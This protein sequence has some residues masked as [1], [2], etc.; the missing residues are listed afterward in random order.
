MAWA[1]FEKNTRMSKSFPTRAACWAAAKSSGLVVD[2]V[3]EDKGT[4][5]QELEGD[6]EIKE[7]SEAAA[8]GSAPPSEADEVA[9][10]AG[11]PL[12]RPHAALKR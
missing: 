12:S 4:V 3:N 2:R 5:Q 10:D 6:Y 8:A 9:E 1:L 7:V 11:I